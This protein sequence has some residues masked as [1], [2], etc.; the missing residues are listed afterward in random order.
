MLLIGFGAAGLTERPRGGM[1]PIK[2][3][4]AIIPLLVSGGLVCIG[5][6][7]VPLHT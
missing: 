4:G 1:G 2:F 5:I 6:D 7:K 3:I